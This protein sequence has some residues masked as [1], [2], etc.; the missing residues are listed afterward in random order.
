M[1]P[2]SS[3]CGVY[4]SHPDSRYFGVGKVDRDQVEEYAA[5]KSWKLAEAERWL[6]PLLNY[7]PR[8]DKA[9]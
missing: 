5:R 8:K 6:G 9:A 4:L 2:S 1:W 3:V 7:D